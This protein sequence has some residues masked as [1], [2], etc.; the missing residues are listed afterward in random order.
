V[1][2]SAINWANIAELRIAEERSNRRQKILTASLA[3]LALALVL[4]LLA[5]SCG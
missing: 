4:V 2:R 1:K 3:V 5:K